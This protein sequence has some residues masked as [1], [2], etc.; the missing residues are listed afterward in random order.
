MPD[1]AR[2]LSLPNFSPFG[3]TVAEGA[4]ISRRNAFPTISRI[5]PYDAKAM[6]VWE[7]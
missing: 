7:L 5:R 2:V 1:L 4:K 6:V 3:V